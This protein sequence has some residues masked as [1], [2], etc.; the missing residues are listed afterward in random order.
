MNGAEIR[1]SSAGDGEAVYRIPS[2]LLGGV[3]DLCRI[4]LGRAAIA[5]DGGE[6]EAEDEMFRCL[7]CSASGGEAKD[8]FGSL[9]M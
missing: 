6:G 7:G 5:R 2:K 3:E 8:E 4:H 1:G 9:S